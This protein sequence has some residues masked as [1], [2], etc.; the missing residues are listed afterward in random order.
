METKRL[1]RTPHPSVSVLLNNKPSR[2]ETGA[3]HRTR[4]RVVP[5]SKRLLL[6][7]MGPPTRN[8]F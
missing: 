4:W 1:V 2:D 3:E 6:Y 5:K 7:S 8:T